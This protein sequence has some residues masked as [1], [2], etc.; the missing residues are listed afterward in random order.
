[1]FNKMLIH[2]KEGKKRETMEQ[3]SDETTENKYYDKKYGYQ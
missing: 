3:I 1:M 2:P